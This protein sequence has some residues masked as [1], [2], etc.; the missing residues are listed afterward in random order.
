V[1]VLTGFGTF[2]DW[3]KE[4]KM[5]CVLA[6]PL[7]IYAELL[8]HYADRLKEVADQIFEDYIQIR[9]RENDQP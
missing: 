8:L 5:G 3:E 2:N 6:D 9:L 1:D 4:Q 7:L